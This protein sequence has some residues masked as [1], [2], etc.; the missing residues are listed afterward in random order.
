VVGSANNAILL[1]TDG[2]VVPASKWNLLMNFCNMTLLFKI[3][4]AATEA[5]SS[6]LEELGE[7]KKLVGCSVS[8][9]L[10]NIVINLLTASEKV[11]GIEDMKSTTSGFFT[12]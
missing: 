10:F 12:P 9:S 8:L 4:S 6:V 3:E 1:L 5:P 2:V 7:E 11:S